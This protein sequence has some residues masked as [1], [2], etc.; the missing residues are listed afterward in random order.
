M[1]LFPLFYGDGFSYW[2]LPLNDLF[3]NLPS[4]FRSLLNPSSVVWHAKL[5][6]HVSK[7]PQKSDEI[8]KKKKVET[9]SIYG[10][11]IL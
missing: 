8:L 9:T 6:F 10:L 2:I 7:S 5:P 1:K 3:P 4:S 11:F